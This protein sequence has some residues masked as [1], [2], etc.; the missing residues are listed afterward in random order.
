[1]NCVQLTKEK[2]WDV[3]HKDNRK[4]PMELL[5]T[6]KAP[7]IQHNI[8]NMIKMLNAK[9]YP[10]RSDTKHLQLKIEWLPLGIIETESY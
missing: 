8:E 4:N 3:V 1:M 10:S 9:F 5:V 7:N 6:A 2:I